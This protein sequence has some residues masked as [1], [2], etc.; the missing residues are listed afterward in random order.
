MTGFHWVSLGIT[1]LLP[2]FTGFYWDLPSF[3]GF[4]WVLRDFTGFYW[5][6]PGFTGFHWVSLGFTGF[7]YGLWTRSRV[8]QRDRSLNHVSG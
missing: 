8:I 3:T 1:G 2:G 6:L 4:Y 5:V 7:H